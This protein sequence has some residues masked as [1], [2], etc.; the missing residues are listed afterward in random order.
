MVR[1]TLCKENYT[2]TLQSVTNAH[3]KNFQSVSKSHIVSYKM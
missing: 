1:I 2:E 3:K